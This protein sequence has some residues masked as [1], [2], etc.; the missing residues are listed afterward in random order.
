[1]FCAVIYWSV[2]FKKRHTILDSWITGSINLIALYNKTIIAKI[3]MSSEA[4]V[5]NNQR[6]LPTWFYVRLCLMYGLIKKNCSV[7]DT[8][9]YF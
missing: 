1:V 9:F 5:S 4:I 2:E 8:E 6:S 7:G 3:E